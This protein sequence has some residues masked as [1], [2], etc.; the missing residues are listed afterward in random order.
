MHT[1][2]MHPM[3]HIPS[4]WPTTAVE[5]DQTCKGGE[6]I[7]HSSKLSS[8]LLTQLPT[9][10]LTLVGYPVVPSSAMTPL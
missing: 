6:A 10:T 8:Q 4:H 3:G 7:Q 5:S 1:A 2:H 9:L